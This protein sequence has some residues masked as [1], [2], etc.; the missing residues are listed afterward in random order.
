MQLSAIPTKLIDV[1]NFLVKDSKTR[2]VFILINGKRSLSEI[3]DLLKVEMQEGVDLISMMLEK[4][5]LQFLDE[6][7]TTDQTSATNQVISGNLTK[8]MS[9]KVFLNEVSDELA[10]FIGPVASIIMADFE[11][12]DGELDK[13]TCEKVIN[14]IAKEIDDLDEK[15]NFIKSVQTII[16]NAS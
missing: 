14:A 6:G 2:R 7:T 4:G 13:D 15:Q 10:K 1:A 11:L 3:F 12:G 9:T 16:S 8:S 5:Y